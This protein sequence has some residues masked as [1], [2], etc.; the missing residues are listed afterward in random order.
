M[1]QNKLKLVAVIILTGFLAVLYNDYYMGILFLAVVICPFILFAVLCYV[2]V[3]LS[4]EL[5]TVVHVAGKGETIPISVQVHNP[6]VFPVAV[7]CI[8]VSY[9]NSF[10][11]Q[12][13]EHKQVFY[14][15]VDSRS[16][17]NATC[18]LKSE[19]AGNIIISLSKVK[20]FDYLK[21]FSLRKKNLG[22]LKVAVLPNYYEL[23]EDL[24]K[25]RSRMQIESDYYSSTKSGDDPSEV[26]AIREYREGDRPQRIHWKL[27]LK[28]DQLMIK[29][30]SEPLNC[31]V[32][33]LADFGISGW[34]EAL[35]ITDSLLEC[36]LSLSYSFML[37]GQIHYIAW[38]DKFQ[39]SSRRIRIVTEKDLF[40]AIDGLLS[41]GPYLH[42]VN[43]AANYYAE[44]PNDQY[45]D[46]FYVTNI[47][48]DEKLDS[49]IW[50]KAIGRQILYISQGEQFCVRD[51]SKTQ[52][53]LP[54]SKELAGKIF[55][56]GIGL[57]SVSSSD[58][59]AGLENLKFN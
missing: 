9:T 44:Y 26:F 54:V 6:T 59:K 23:T 34:D 4:V 48:T 24:L 12:F 39:G 2:H 46:L 41:C 20:V 43:L 33:I 58:I 16:T 19:Y 37:K 52:R 1:L 11:E 28:Q 3:R 27:S 13:K 57:F 38:Y 32:V 31:S 56:T 51:N 30:F 15:S 18:N 17:T 14:I 50:I 22:E 7:I 53:A 8:T 47:I 36:T 25:D 35:D 5:T 45:T 10:S 40:E 29:D 21:I 42:D 55:E 49:L